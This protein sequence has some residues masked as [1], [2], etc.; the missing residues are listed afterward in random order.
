MALKV[1][2]LRVEADEA[3]IQLM[4]MVTVH[5]LHLVVALQEMAL[6]HALLLF[7]HDPVQAVRQLV[8]FQEM[9][10]DLYEPMIRWFDTSVDGSL[11]IILDLQ[12]IEQRLLFLN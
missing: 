7:Q 1:L 9:H 10:C 2:A 6:E 11:S 4:L 8:Q 5:R 12:A 3:E